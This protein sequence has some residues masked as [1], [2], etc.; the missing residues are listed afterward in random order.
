MRRLTFLMAGS[1]R[2]PPG[3]M[4]GPWLPVHH[5]PPTPHVV[6]QQRPCFLT[7]LCDVTDQQ[8]LLATTTTDVKVLIAEKVAELVACGSI[9]G[10]VA[11]GGFDLVL[12][13]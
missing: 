5:G 4:T 2:M 6:W 7:R 8:A 3:L 1:Y 9:G 13:L 10:D 11:C 12:G